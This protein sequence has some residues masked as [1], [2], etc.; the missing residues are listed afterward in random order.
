MPLIGT[1]LLNLNLY[2]NNRPQVKKNLLSCEFIFLME[3]CKNARSLCCFRLYFVCGKVDMSIADMAELALRTGFRCLC[4]LGRGGS[5]SL[6]LNYAYSV[7]KL[8]FRNTR[9]ILN[10][11]KRH[12]SLFTQ[13]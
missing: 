6:I 1:K 10:N 12:R 5:T 7:L 9:V 13:S 3:L 11:F 2:Q 4:P 8:L